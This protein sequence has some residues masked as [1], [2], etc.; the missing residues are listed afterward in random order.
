MTCV[1]GVSKVAAVASDYRSSIDG[2]VC[3]LLAAGESSPP[4]RNI[5]ATTRPTYSVAIISSE[6]ARLLKHR[7]G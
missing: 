4:G 5:I 7:R 1:Q 3:C 6:I 2:G